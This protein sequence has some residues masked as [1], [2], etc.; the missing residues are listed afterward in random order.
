M[1]GSPR[2]GWAGAVAV[3]RDPDGSRGSHQALR[4][5]DHTKSL[6]C[7]HTPASQPQ[8]SEREMSHTNHPTPHHPTPY[9]SCFTLSHLKE[10]CPTPP[11]T[12]PHHPKPSQPHSQPSEGEISHTTAYH[13]TPYQTIL[14][15]TSITPN[16]LKDRCSTPHHSKDADE[17]RMGFNPK[18]FVPQGGRRYYS[19]NW[20][21][22]IKPTCNLLP[23][24]KVSL[25]SDSLFCYQP[26]MNLH[27]K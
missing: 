23:T 19:C 24:V 10:R 7:L 27:R 3:L 14:Y 13:T 15:H 17:T 26:Q 22:W 25:W 8:T 1:N 6:I 2:L 12:T 4:W 20:M 21:L 5:R 11:H 16:R 9:H 18:W